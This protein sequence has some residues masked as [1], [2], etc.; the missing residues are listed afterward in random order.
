MHT[1]MK[2]TNLDYLKLMADGD[3]NMEQTMLE[4]LIEELPTEFD[5]MKTLYTAKDWKELSQVSHKMKSTL[6]F[7]GNDELTAAN[8]KIE[9]LT[10]QDSLP[11]IEDVAILEEMMV[12]FEGA[13]P[14]VM[15]E[16]QTIA[17]R[18]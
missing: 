13:L 14:T 18:Y 15:E 8:L 4:M 1:T 6:A 16:L 7:I 12:K 11:S 17:E 9:H 3:L 5:K 2:L 10:K